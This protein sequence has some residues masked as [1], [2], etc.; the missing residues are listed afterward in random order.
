M[1]LS[2]PRAPF[3]IVPRLHRHYSCTSPFSLLSWCSPTISGA[4]TES[5][6]G[7]AALPYFLDEAHCAN[8][9]VSSCISGT[10]LHL[11][12]VLLIALY[13]LICFFV[14]LP[15]SCLQTGNKKGPTPPNYSLHWLE[16]SRKDGWNEDM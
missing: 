16:E 7:V 2:S 14:L 6:R 3:Q 15:A 4:S 9:S 10:H 8:R 1:Y 5:L 11:R 13:L 12:G